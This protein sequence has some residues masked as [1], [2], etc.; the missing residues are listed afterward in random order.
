MSDQSDDQGGMPDLGALLGGLTGGGGGGLGDLFA[1]ATQAMSAQQEAAAAV[2]EGSAGGGAVKLTMTGAGDLTDLS[3]SPAAVDPDDVAGLED[4]ILAAFRDAQTRI[5]EIH[6]QA[7][8]GFDPG[9]MLGGL[10]GSDEE[11]EGGGLGGFAGLLG[12]LRGGADDEDI[13]DWDGD[14]DGDAESE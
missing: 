7:M 12:G 9:A 1:Q 3:I 8:G 11:E 6:A 5:A 2:V 4:L 14:E 10:M 13:D